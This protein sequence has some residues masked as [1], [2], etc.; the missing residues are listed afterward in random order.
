MKPLR[1]NIIYE[2]LGTVNQLISHHKFANM[3]DEGLEMWWNG[4]INQ[5]VFRIKQKFYY[6][7]INRQHDHPEKFRFHVRVMT[8]SIV[9]AFAKSKPDSAKYVKNLVKRLIS[10]RCNAP[11]ILKL[12]MMISDIYHY[13]VF[14]LLN[15]PQKTIT[16]PIDYEDADVNFSGSQKLEYPEGSDKRARPEDHQGGACYSDYY[17]N[18][19]KSGSP[20]AR[21]KE[22]RNTEFYRLL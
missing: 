16:V 3:D 7:D 11:D 17:P 5:I 4:I 9:E 19:P 6:F 13:S 1:S 18:M 12:Q 14:L 20:D 21:F 8:N 2:N 15:N 10:S 22:Y